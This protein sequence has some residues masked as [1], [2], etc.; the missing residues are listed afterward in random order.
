VQALIEQRKRWAAKSSGY[1]LFF[2]RLLTLSAFAMNAL[3]VLLTLL[4]LFDAFSWWHLALL[5]MAKWI[6]DLLLLV[7]T[8]SFFEQKT[9][10]KWYP[11][12]SLIYPF[13]TMFVALS[14]L[15]SN[16]NW[17]GRTFKK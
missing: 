16:Y 15:F 12:S 2:S 6:V 13:F 10:L 8:A 3:I 9:V 5:F 1:R 4:S 14:S 11:I 7:K 17:K